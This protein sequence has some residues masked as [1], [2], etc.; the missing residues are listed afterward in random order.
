MLKKGKLLCLVLSAILGLTP[1]TAYA[2]TYTVEKEQ[3]QESLNNLGQSGEKKFIF[4]DVSAASGNWKYES[5]KYVYDKN[6]MSNITGT[7]EFRPDIPLTRSMFATVLYRMAGEPSVEYTNKF[8]DVPAGKWYSS[9][10]LWANQKGMVNGYGDGRYGIDD[11]ITREQIAK[12]LYLYGQSAGYNVS[13]KADISS[14][15]DVS[16]I[17]SWGVESFQWAV[18]AQMVSGKP[19]GDGTFR[20]DAKGQATRA[21]CAKM[22]KMFM[23]KYSQ[24]EEQD[25]VETD[26]IEEFY[27]IVSDLI[28]EYEGKVDTSSLS[29]QDIETGKG[30]GRVIV[31]TDKTLP[32]LSKFEPAV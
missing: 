2:G 18:D 24:Q 5:V 30:S 13:G 4:T 23:E 9:A 15:T 8:S 7:T 19:N 12:M 21:E 10:I 25:V 11:N 28:Q 16:S 20:L 29:T 1:V 3:K 17:S 31:S 26:T 22:L 27:R 6:I 14:F 32:S